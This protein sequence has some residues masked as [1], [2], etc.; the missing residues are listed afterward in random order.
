M[1]EKASAEFIIFD[2][3]QFQK[4][5]KLFNFGFFYYFPT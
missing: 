2:N 4:F 3:Y 1:N 5:H